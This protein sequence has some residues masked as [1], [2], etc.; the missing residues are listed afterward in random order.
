MEQREA[1]HREAPGAVHGV[2]PPIFI[3]MFVNGRA[4]PPVQAI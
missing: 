3:A 2:V 1:A 4:P